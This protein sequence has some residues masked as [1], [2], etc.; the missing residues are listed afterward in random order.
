MV[1]DFER[2]SS[3]GGDIAT[4]VQIDENGEYTPEEGYVW[5]KVVVAVPQEQ[6]ETLK[7]VIDGSI[8]DLVIPS[9]VTR[10]K[11]YA[12]YK[13]ET[14]KSVVIP[15]GVTYLGIAAFQGCTGLTEIT[16]PAS[17]NLIRFDAFSDCSGLTSFTVLGTE[18]GAGVGILERTTC[19][20]YVPAEAVDT[21]KA[22]QNWSAYADRIQAIPA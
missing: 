17:M 15:E 10:I 16:I 22:A 2:Y 7:G 18:T 20:I 12:F 21:Y 19:P 3:L 8:E 6:N 1:I 11:H 5:N 13:D 9:G 4:Q 14:I